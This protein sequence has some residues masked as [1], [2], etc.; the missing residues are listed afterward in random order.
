MNKNQR[1]DEEL[2]NVLTPDQF[3]VCR[4]GGTE[5]AFSGEL[6]N[7]TKTGMY[8]CVVCG[9]PLF[10][11]KTKFDSGTGWPSFSDAIETGSVLLRP[12]ESL[13]MHRTEVLCSQCHSHLGHV[14]EDGPQ[15]L[16]DGTPA[17]GKRYCINSTALNFIEQKEV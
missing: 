14:F 13:G 16:E 15:V 7:N 12:D 4:E 17:T 11:S 6:Y 5:P 10:S 3:H 2:K 8:E 1:T 9:Q